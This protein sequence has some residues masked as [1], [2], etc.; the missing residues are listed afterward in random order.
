[1]ENFIHKELTYKIIGAAYEVY[2]ALGSGFLEKVYE[3]AMLIELESV[4]LKVQQQAPIKVTYNGKTIGEYFA[5][6]LVEEKVIVELKSVTELTSIHE[7]QLVN[8][9]RATGMRVGLLINFGD[10]IKVKRK[11]L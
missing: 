2:N 10:K 8:Y 6:L 7:V 11:V 3:N 5:D 1:M 4:G 9:L